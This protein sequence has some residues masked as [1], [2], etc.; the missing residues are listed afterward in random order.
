LAWMAGEEVVS[1][2]SSNIA[3]TV[4]ALLLGFWSIINSFGVK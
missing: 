4:A 3:F 1:P 2:C